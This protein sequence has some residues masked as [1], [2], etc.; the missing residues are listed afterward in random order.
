MLSGRKNASSLG[1]D[2]APQG[3]LN[4]ATALPV[5]LHLPGCALPPRPSGWRVDGSLGG[6][7]G[8]AEVEGLDIMATLL[9]GLKM[10]LRYLKFRHA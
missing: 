5:G 7:F 9:I 2:V 1:R 6:C 8:C 3:R 10:G 4:G